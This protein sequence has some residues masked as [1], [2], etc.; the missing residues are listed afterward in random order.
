MSRFLLLA[1]LLAAPAAAHGPNGE[2]T[3]DDKIEWLDPRH[4]KFFSYHAYLAVMR[5]A[6]SLGREDWEKLDGAAQHKRVAEDEK[7]LMDRFEALIR[8]HSRLSKDDQEFVSSI[9]G[10]DVAS[11]LAAVGNARHDPNLSPAARESMLKERLEALKE[12]ATRAGGSFDWRRIF[13]GAQA[14][15]GSMPEHVEREAATDHAAARRVE[16]FLES[17]ASPEVRRVLASK[18][19]FVAFLNEREVPAVALPSLGAVYDVMSRAP[20]KER[21]ELR[22]ILPTI[23]QFLKD[24]KKIELENMPGAAGFAVPGDY[25]VPQMVGVTTELG[26]LDPLVAASHI[27]TH[28]FQHIYDMYVGRHYT[29]DS[30]MRGFKS[31]V[32]FYSAL[33]KSSPGRYEQL[34]RGADEESRQYI[35]FA[36]MYGEEYHKGPHQF[37][38]C[39]AYRINYNQWHEGVFNGRVPLREAVTPLG[40]PRQLAAR[41][42]HV[43]DLRAQVAKLEVEQ[44]ALR[45]RRGSGPSSR[46]L[47]NDFERVV[48][49]LRSARST[50]ANKQREA[51]V[52]EMRIQRMQSEVAWL[53]KKGGPGVEPFDLRLS[54]DKTYMTP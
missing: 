42:A 18:K 28:E 48:R 15:S 25:D 3:G 23:V 29:I 16:T 27:I 14:P 8:A 41:R 43:D 26:K 34:A 52:Q 45:R 54:V 46:A 49:D 20:E 1:L 9:W 4:S 50:L 32:L 12:T 51:D 37:H 5:G 21:E 35:K 33:K 39:I 17:L 2:L 6:R 30:E 53:D 36:E 19:S 7:F 24:G 47:D 13:D 38:D 40:A 31:A 22:H 10:E 44:E 11:A